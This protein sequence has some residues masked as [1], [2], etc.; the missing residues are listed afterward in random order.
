MSEPSLYKRYSLV[1]ALLI[2]A[3]RAAAHRFPFGV[4]VR[5]D[6]ALA[7]AAPASVSNGAHRFRGTGAPVG[8]GTGALASSDF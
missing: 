3:L 8:L 7:D 4:E 1:P 2:I 5:Q 6:R